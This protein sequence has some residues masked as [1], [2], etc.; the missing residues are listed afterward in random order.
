MKRKA[1]TSSI[2]KR[3]RTVTP[4]SMEMIFSILLLLLP[5]ASVLG[6]S[7]IGNEPVRTRTFG[8]K[9]TYSDSSTSS[10]PATTTILSASRNRNMNHDLLDAPTSSPASSTGDNA[11]SKD[12]QAVDEYLEFLDRRYR[13]VCMLCPLLCLPARFYLLETRQ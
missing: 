10:R 1:S 11:S 2:F 3:E 6:F 8:T 5:T 9:S 13:Y 4:L 7:L 12:E